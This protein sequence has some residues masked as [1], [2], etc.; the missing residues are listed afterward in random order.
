MRKVRAAQEHNVCTLTAHRVRGWLPGLRTTAW[1]KSKSWETQCVRMA[2]S[3]SCCSLHSAC[4]AK[5]ALQASTFQHQAGSGW[6]RK[7]PE[8]WEEGREE[9][10]CR[11]EPQPAALPQRAV[12]T[13]G[14][15]ARFPPEPCWALRQLRLPGCERHTGG[16][17]LESE[18]FLWG[19]EGPKPEFT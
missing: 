4:K 6:M 12:N 11:A 10:T 14:K 17:Y 8:E 16:H 9:N 1:K 3:S 15:G 18:R 13:A 19:F 7:L 5:T 2:V